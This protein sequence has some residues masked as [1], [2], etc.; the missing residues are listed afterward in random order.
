VADPKPRTPTQRQREALQ[1][2]AAGKVQYGIEFPNMTRRAA[3]RGRDA[4]DVP[5]YLIDDLGAG[6]RSASLAA[7][8]ERHWITVR[9]DLIPTHTV[10]EKTVTT[11]TLTGTQKRVLPEHPEPVD[12]GWR[13]TVELTPLG[14]AA[15]DSSHLQKGADS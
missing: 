9:H 5:K 3:A 8:E 15:L 10:P 1:L 7:C 12:P 2:V 14:R 4:F 13:T 6:S 11:R